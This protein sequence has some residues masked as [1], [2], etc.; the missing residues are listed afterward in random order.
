MKN[1]LLSLLIFFT[2]VTSIPAAVVMYSDRSAWR[3]AAGGVGDIVDNLNTGTY[4]SSILGRGSYAITSNDLALFPNNNPVT[5]IDGSGYFHFFL[6]ADRPHYFDRDLGELV[7]TSND[8]ISGFATFTFDNAIYAFGFD[9]NPYSFDVGEV[10]SVALNGV[11]ASSYSLPATDVTGFRGFVS[12]TAFTT[13][14]M[15][16]TGATSYTSAEHGMDNIEAFTA[17]APE[18]SRALLLF[19]GGAALN[20]R[21]R[22]CVARA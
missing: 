11:S 12:D 4:N 3:S 15:S 10:V 16:I 5:T 18:P 13:A 19:L 9:L 2:A 1:T 8:Y 6:S 20:R 21:R 14:T 22:R 7:Y 17:A